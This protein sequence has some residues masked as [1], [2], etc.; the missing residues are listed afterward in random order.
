MPPWSGRRLTLL[1]S[2][3]GGSRTSAAAPSSSFPREL[4]EARS[5]F[6]S[7]ALARDTLAG[8]QAKK[9]KWATFCN[10]F[11][12]SP[13]DFS[14]GNLVDYITF[15]GTQANRG[16]PMAY[17][18]IKA[19]ASFLGRALSYSAPHLPNPV[20]HPEVQLFLRGVA[21]VLG[22]KVEKAVPCTLD[23]LRCI[24]RCAAS[25]PEDPEW[26]TTA[27]MAS[28]AFWGCLRLGALAPKRAGGTALCLGD[29]SVSG[30]SLILTLTASK[31][32]QFRERVHRVEVPAQ[33][34]PDLCPLRCFTRWISGW[35]LPSSRLR[36][37]ALSTTVP[38]TLSRSRF[39]ELVNAALGLR[40]PDH[41]TGH[42]F[43]R[44]FVRLALMTGTPIWQVMHHG[45]WR[46]LEV[47]LSYAEDTLIPNPLG[48]VSA[49][50]L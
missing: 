4:Q 7:N 48:G 15:L 45:D 3:L 23:Q 41:L 10:T 32:N 50:A 11:Q 36:L 12:R 22:K 25:H 21:R 39:L 2:D 16:D 6:W 1:S 5:V 24:L 20:Q 27:L 42:S 37:S 28:V 33:L 19:Y 31:T 9:S 38:S 14:P 35:Q 34:D 40:P 26:R 47:V 30:T 13:C 43:R 18:S 29:L 49:L 44:G 17:S 8:Y 46:T